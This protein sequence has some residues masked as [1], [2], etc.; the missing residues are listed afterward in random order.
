MKVKKFWLFKLPNG[1]S[2]MV[3]EKQYFCLI[4]GNNASGF[5]LILA[6]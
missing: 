3:Q 1:K 2:V 5:H 6:L 4:F